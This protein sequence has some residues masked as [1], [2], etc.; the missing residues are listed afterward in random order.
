MNKSHNWVGGWVYYVGDRFFLSGDLLSS[1]NNKSG[2]QTAEAE[3]RFL[4]ATN[5]VMS[6]LGED[7]GRSFDGYSDN[8]G[9]GTLA[10]DA[11]DSLVLAD[12]DGIA[13]GALYVHRLLLAGG[14]GQID[15]I[16]GNGLNIYYDLNEP[17]NVYLGGQTYSLAGGGSIS[18]VPE[19][20]LLFLGA[21]GALGAASRRR[22][23]R[24]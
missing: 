24:Q 11:G 18:P 17:A 1:S 3:L 20:Q 22:M 15:H 10:L 14:T 16:A 6:V 2:W 21:L 12:G 13:G 9:W 4:G 7:L 5:H 8:F 23:K 19:P